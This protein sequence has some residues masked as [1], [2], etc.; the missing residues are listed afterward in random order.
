M[1]ARKVFC[2]AVPVGTVGQLTPAQHL[3]ARLAPMRPEWRVEVEALLVFEEARLARPL[4]HEET[5]RAVALAE[6]VLR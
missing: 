6:A 5:L 4:T 1:A 2:Y 3:A